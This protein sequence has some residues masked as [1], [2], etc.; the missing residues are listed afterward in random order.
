MR[1]LTYHILQVERKLNSAEKWSKCNLCYKYLRSLPSKRR[2]IINYVCKLKWNLLYTVDL[3]T[4]LDLLTCV[5]GCFRYTGRVS[6]N[7]W[8]TNYKDKNIKFNEL[9]IEAKHVICR[10]IFTQIFVFHNK[11]WLYINYQL[12]CTDFYL[13]IKY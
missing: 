9:L 12:F 2:K 11:F 5:G 1:C 3:A 7:A 6:N 8:A 4:I 10:I 13:F